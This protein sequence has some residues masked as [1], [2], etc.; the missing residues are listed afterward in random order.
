M[1]GL[2]IGAVILGAFIGLYEYR[3]QQMAPH[4]PQETTMPAVSEPSANSAAKPAPKI[5]E[6]KPVPIPASPVSPV[7]E[8]P[9]AATEPTAMTTDPAM[10]ID[11]A[12][13]PALPTEPAPAGTVPAA[14]KTIVTITQPVKVATPF[15]VVVIRPG[16]QAKIVSREGGNVSVR[17]LNN[18]VSVPLASTDL[19]EAPIAAPAEAVPVAPRAATPPPLVKPPTSLF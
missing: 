9:V 6:A 10:T 12:M 14:P 7:M 17:Y 18:T 1:R 5:A 11:P 19:G 8:A 3:K 4:T 13:A 16:T 15:G 2:L